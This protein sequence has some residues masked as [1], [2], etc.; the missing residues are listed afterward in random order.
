MPG[1][2]LEYFSTNIFKENGNSLRELMD[3]NMSFMDSY[4]MVITCIIVLVD[5]IDGLVENLNIR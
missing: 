1:L 5:L 3:A 4:L 2:L